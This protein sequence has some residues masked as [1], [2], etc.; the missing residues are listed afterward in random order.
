MPQHAAAQEIFPRD[1]TSLVQTVFLLHDLHTEL[2]GIGVQA[3]YTLFCAPTTFAHGV[4][5][6]QNALFL[7]KIPYLHGKSCFGTGNS[8]VSSP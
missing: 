2:M 6:S 8:L 3:F 7:T 4:A 1:R 5:L